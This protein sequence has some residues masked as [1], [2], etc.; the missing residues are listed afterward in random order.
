MLEAE[1]TPVQALSFGTI[2]AA[3]PFL[4]LGDK[5]ARLSQ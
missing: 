1:A 2:V 4:R 5:I 3:D